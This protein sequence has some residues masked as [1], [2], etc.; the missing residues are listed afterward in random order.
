[1]KNYI[2]IYLVLSGLLFTVGCQQKKAN[3]IN[4]R[5]TEKQK[6]FN[7]E[8]LNF[9]FVD[10]PYDEVKLSKILHKNNDKSNWP[11]VKITATF[12]GFISAGNNNPCRGCDHCG[13]CIGLCVEVEKSKL[14]Y[15]DLTTTEVSNGDV[16]FDIVDD[17][18]NHKIIMIPYQNIDNGDGYLHVDG[19]YSFSKE[20][21]DFLGRN[22]VI[23]LGSY[24]IDYS[25]NKPFGIVAINTN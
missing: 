13:C 15:K 16:M 21:S 6:S 8:G 12:G 2:F 4:K 11:K 20:V 24:K 22:I 10:F 7:P 1:M 5:I 25:T 18:T 3:S 19:N 23:F 17:T 14:I 9:G